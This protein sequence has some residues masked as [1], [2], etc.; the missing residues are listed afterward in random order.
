MFSISRS[1]LSTRRD[2]TVFAMSLTHNAVV[3]MFALLVGVGIWFNGI[4]A[5]ILTSPDQLTTKDYDF[6]IV[7]GTPSTLNILL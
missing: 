1:S 7:G 3:P 5:K 4:Q 2:I 6:V